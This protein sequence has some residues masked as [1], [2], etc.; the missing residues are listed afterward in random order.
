MDGQLVYS[1]AL[2]LAQAQVYYHKGRYNLFLIG[3]QVVSFLGSAPAL[4]DCWEE[5]RCLE[6]LIL[7]DV[8]KQ[9]VASE[10]V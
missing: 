1:E 5:I 7:S 3:D 4:A 10:S 6:R 9:T 8:F 2:G